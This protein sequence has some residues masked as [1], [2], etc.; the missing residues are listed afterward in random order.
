MLWAIKPLFSRFDELFSRH[1]LF[2]AFF[3][4]K[5]HLCVSKQTVSTWHEETVQNTTL[6]KEPLHHNASFSSILNN[7]DSFSC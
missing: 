2:K 4:Y 3:D 7:Y 6:K 1:Y 5:S